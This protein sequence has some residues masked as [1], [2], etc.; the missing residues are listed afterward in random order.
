MPRKSRLMNVPADALAYTNNCAVV[1]TAAVA[2]VEYSKAHEACVHHG[3]AQ[4][5]MYDYQYHNAIRDLG[6]EVKWGILDGY[7]GMTVA[8]AVRQLPKEG[9]FLVQINRHVFAVVDG[10]VVDTCH[11]SRARVQTVR[12]VEAPEEPTSPAKKAR[13]VD[14]DALRDRV[15]RIAAEAQRQGVSE[16][17]LRAALGR[18]RKQGIQ[19]KSLGD[20]Y[21][22]IG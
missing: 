21:F 13:K 15:I 8:Q 5:G 20:T 3:F 9:R 18:M 12:R 4:K 17:K 2:G 6:A 1:A 16:D 14:T 19:V 11:K 22:Y 10:E 7:V